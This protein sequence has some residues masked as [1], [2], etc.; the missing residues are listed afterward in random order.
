[1]DTEPISTNE[2]YQLRDRVCG[3]WPIEIGREVDLNL[4]EKLRK[5]IEKAGDY[6]LPYYDPR[7]SR[8]D[9]PAQIFFVTPGII[10]HLD[11][12]HQKGQVITAN[13][14]LQ[15][16]MS[17]AKDAVNPEF[18]S[19][20]FNAINALY[21]SSATDSE[22][23]GVP[24]PFDREANISKAIVLF[25]QHAIHRSRIAIQE[26]CS[27]NRTS[28]LYSM[29]RALNGN[30]GL[31][32]T[33]TDFTTESLPDED[34][35][36]GL[37]GENFQVK[38]QKL[39][40][41]ESSTSLPENERYD[42]IIATYAFDS[43]WLPQDVRYEKFGDQWYKVKYRIKVGDIDPDRNEFT[44]AD[45]IESLKKGNS[46][47]GTHGYYRRIAIE[48]AV[49]KINIK[50]VPFG[51]TIEGRYGKQERVAINVPGGLIQ[52]VIDSFKTKLRSDGVFIIGD[53]AVNNPNGFVKNQDF[54]ADFSTA[55]DAAKYKCEDYGLAK[56]ILEKMGFQA[57]LFDVSDF[58]YKYSQKAQLNNDLPGHLIM[59]VRRKAFSLG[60]LLQRKN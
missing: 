9:I 4:I 58:V 18:T 3:V 42:S 55:G 56:Q 49:E 53:V 24:F 19:D 17:N 46:E 28:R 1:M 37:T 48:R 8:T 27:G 38:T 32:I 7:E 26:I 57:E 35:L 59:I 22:R 30:R 50:E 51:D 20:V 36:N 10:E 6:N 14:I 12:L 44:K 29:R 11:K 31:D 45:V 47:K 41:L 2:D 39:N 13:D 43:V 25:L 60:N 33:L 16:L 15:L 54:A 34:K 5:K 40:L 52:N 21:Y 23:I